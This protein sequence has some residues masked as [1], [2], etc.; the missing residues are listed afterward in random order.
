MTHEK[1]IS[2]ARYMKIHHDMSDTSICIRSE[3]SCTYSVGDV[4]RLR[5]WI[6]LDG[7]P[8]NVGHYTGRELVRVVVAVKR[9]AYGLH[10][11]AA[12]IAHRRVEG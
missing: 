9:G 4:L 8:W 6:S 11:G 12:A 5:E 1:R 3:A 2:R 10:K 7:Q